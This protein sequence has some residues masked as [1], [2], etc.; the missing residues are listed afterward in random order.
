ASGRSDSREPS[1]DGLLHF[2][3]EF[4]RL[5]A[6]GFDRLADDHADRARLFSQPASRPVRA[7]IVGQRHD[8][9]AG[10]DREQRAAHPELASVS[11]DYP[12]AFR[13]DDDPQTVPEP[14]L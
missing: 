4:P 9:L 7:G 3:V 2:L 11:G 5:L 14:G 6:G 12:S 13:K 10:F 1:L 8:A